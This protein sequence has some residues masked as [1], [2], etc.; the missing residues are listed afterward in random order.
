[1]HLVEKSSKRPEGVLESES[2]YDLDVLL[3]FSDLMISIS[4]WLKPLV[5]EISSIGF[6]GMKEKFSEPRPKTI[7]T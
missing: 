2:E 1:M 6:L 4:S 3:A 7:Y 5:H